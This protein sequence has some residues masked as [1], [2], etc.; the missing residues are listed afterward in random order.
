MSLKTQRKIMF[1]PVIN[2]MTVFFFIQFIRKNN[3]E[4]RYFIKTW[5]RILLYF[6]IIVVISEVVIVF[7]DN[8]LIKYIAEWISTYFILFMIAFQSVKAQEKR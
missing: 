4:T 3:I 1:I 2:F 6:L 8:Q 7:L 5:I